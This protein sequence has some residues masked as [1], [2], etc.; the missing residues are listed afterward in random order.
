MPAQPDLLIHKLIEKLGDHDPRIRR[1]AAGALRLHGLRAL[2]A[3]PALAAMLGD[4]DP[5]VRCEVERAL[6]HLRLQAA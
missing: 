5:Y 6:D 2:P 4:E 3:V 1:N